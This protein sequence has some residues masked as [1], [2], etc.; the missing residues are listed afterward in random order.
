MRQERVLHQFELGAPSRIEACRR[1][2]VAP[3]TADTWMQFNTYD[4]RVR[5]R[6]VLERVRTPS[7]R[8]KKPPP[9]FEEFR[10]FYFGHSSPAHQKEWLEAVE[11]NRRVMILQPPSHGKALA[12][13]TPIPT[14][15]GWTT[16]GALKVGDEIFDERGEPTRVAYKSPVMLGRPCY[17]VTFAT[18]DSIVAD[19]DHLWATRSRTSRLHPDA[20]RTTAQIAATVGGSRP[21]HKVRVQDGIRLPE[22]ELPIDPYCLG[23]WL[24]DGHS[25]GA[26][27]T[28]A[29]PVLTE[30]FE[31]AGYP[32]A[33]RRSRNR[34]PN[35]QIGGG[36]AARLREMGLLHNKHI[37]FEYLRASEKQ[38]LAL[39]QGLMDTDGYCNVEG[40]CEFTTTS[41]ALSAGVM[42][43]LISLGFS[44]RS[45]EGRAT[46]Y[47]NDCG[48]KWRITFNPIQ[49]RPVFRL[50]R[51]YGR[52]TETH[53]GGWNAITAVEPVPSVA[54]ACVEVDSPSHLYLA[55]RHMIPT[56]NTTWCEE[57]VVWRVMSDP[58]IRVLFISKTE[59]AAK[60]R[61]FNIASMLGDPTWY[62]RKNL[63]DPIARYGPF[64]PG[65]DEGNLSWSK[66][67]L[68]VSGS[69]ISG[70]DPTVE[71][72]GVGNQIQGARTDLIVLDDICTLSNQITETMREG[73]LNWLGQE[74]LARL[75]EDG[76]NLVII[77][78]RVAGNDVYGTL[79]DKA[80]MQVDG[81]TVGL[82]CLVR[83]A[84]LD[85]ETTAVL[86][87]ENW[88]YEALLA[89]RDDP[90]MRP[91][92]W[93][94]TYQ[95]EALDHPD[96]PF[97]L[98][99]LEEARDNYLPGEVGRGMVTVMG[100][101]PATEGVAALTVIAIDPSSGIRY[102]VDC[103]AQ[104]D[105]KTPDR[106]L[107]WVFRVAQKYRPVDV[108]IEHNNFQGYFARQTEL[109]DGLKR[110]CGAKVSETFTGMNKHDPDH[111]VAHMADLLALRRLRMPGTDSP[112]IVA[113]RKELLSWKGGLGRHKQ[114]Q[115][116]VMS[117]WIA[118]LASEDAIHHSVMPP[119][120]PAPR[121]VAQRRQLMRRSA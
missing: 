29:D 109:I 47:G 116:R 16:M 49:A 104:A 115:D 94:L 46:L 68:Y 48:P 121:F 90:L 79:L 66:T 25:S 111:G 55:G 36:F 57:Y 10:R 82:A 50:E 31:L 87:P 2:G 96:A 107:S 51:K 45:Y 17:R 65:P 119:R 8:S 72:I 24:G 93:A 22:M 64:R 44:P 113:L 62:R 106:I 74:A 99:V 89:R 60:K 14:P 78:T 3:R 86:W 13:D 41:A 52:Q 81:K 95:Q 23:A 38:R 42:E 76:G 77:G 18:G 21:N 97:C 15:E 11:R 33:L 70:R 105:L 120:A 101:D 37:P 91:A 27:L 103:D 20:V 43:L 40:G 34:T 85:E 92:T 54:V 75:P 98:P 71:A 9:D 112:N 110:I 58:S 83:P 19:A 32:M 4:W 26:R 30:E 118:V 6:A 53:R 12:L 35:Y 28:T 88:S 114:K 39:L 102:I 108:R 73:M 67:Q 59:G 84:I 100:M 80:E 69:D 117:M 61:L 7:A 5:E 1:A 63:P 56:H